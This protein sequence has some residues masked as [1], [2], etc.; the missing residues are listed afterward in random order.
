MQIDVTYTTCE[1]C[2]NVIILDGEAWRSP[3]D[4]AACPASGETHAPVA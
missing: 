1:H 4:D 3:D 2:D